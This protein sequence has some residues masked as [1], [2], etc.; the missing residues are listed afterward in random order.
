MKT[1]TTLEQFLYE[2]FTKSTGRT[3]LDSGGAYGYKYEQNQKKTLQQF[4][5]EPEVTIDLEYSEEGSTSEGITPSVNTF[6]YMLQNLELDPLCNDFNSMKCEEW[7]SEEAYGISLEQEDYLQ[8]HNFRIGT[9]FNSYNYES[10]LDHVL[11][12]SYIYSEE[13]SEDYPEYV[14]LQIHLGCD[15]RGG[16]TDAKLYK[17]SRDYFST[18]PQVYGTIDGTEVTTSYNGYD[19]TTD[20][21]IH[22][23]VHKNSVVNLYVEQF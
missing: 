4:L 13:G 3:L 23:P 6:H 8:S 12:G 20:E 7:N 21:G 9:P 2:Q 14:L 17:L 15:V 1:T 10:S 19:F 18:T 11:Q 22:V 16:Y 5:E